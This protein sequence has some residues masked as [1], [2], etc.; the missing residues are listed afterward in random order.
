[1]SGVM[2]K[3]PFIP[4]DKPK[5]WVIFM[6]AGLAGLF[7][8]LC[9]F[10]AAAYHWPVAKTVFIAC[11]FACWGVAFFAGIVCAAGML[12]GHYRGIGEK[13]WRDQVW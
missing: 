10:L 13:P 9:A 6:L 1:M 12:T 11:F 7:S 3:K 4:R 8:G 2:G 5:S